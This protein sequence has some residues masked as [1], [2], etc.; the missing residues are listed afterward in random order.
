MSGLLRR[1][2][3][4][5]G[6]PQQLPCR[7]VTWSQAAGFPTCRHSEEREIPGVPS[8]CVAPTTHDAARAD[9]LAHR[10]VLTAYSVSAT[11]YI[12]SMST[13]REPVGL[14]RARV[15]AEALAL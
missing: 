12:V 1:F 2:A 11:A 6:R 7:R 5:R 10:P 4:G 14:S 8:P 15:C 3:T 9:G 13:R